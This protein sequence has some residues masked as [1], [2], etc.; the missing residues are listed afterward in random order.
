MNSEFPIFEDKS[1]KAFDII[2][3]IESHYVPSHKIGN[4]YVVIETFDGYDVCIIN[5]YGKYDMVCGE[6]YKIIGS[7]D[8]ARKTFQESAKK[9]NE[10]LRSGN[11]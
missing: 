5:E 10:D 9:M 8:D 1:P 6:D 4:K 2:E 7:V 3:I 11:G